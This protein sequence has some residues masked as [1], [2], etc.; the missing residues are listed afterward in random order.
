MSAAPW[1]AVS[2]LGSTGSIGTQALDV[3]ARSEP[4]SFTVT[5]LAATGGRAELLAE[6]AL[7]HHVATVAVT[8]PAQER[9]VRDALGATDVELL[10]GPGAAAALAERS[11]DLVVN[12][13]AGA[14]GL[15]STLAAVRAGNRVGLANKESLIIGGPVVLAALAESAPG[16]PVLERLLP[17]DSEHSALWQCLAGARPGSVAT[18]VLTASGG[19][20]RG[21][22]AETL[23][24]VTP[25]QAL[26]HPTWSMGP[27]ITVNSATLVN[28]GHELIEAAI[29]FA[30]YLTGDPYDAIDVVVHPQ[31]LIHSMVTYVD[32]STLAQ[33]SPPDMRLPISLALGFPERIPGAAPT[34]DWS[35]GVTMTFEPLDRVAFPAVELARAAGRAG[36]TSTAVFTA[37]NEAA[38]AAFLAGHA[39]FPSIVTVVER[40]LAEH[41]VVA[42]P[43]LEDVLHADREARIRATELLRSVAA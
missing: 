3:I 23:H 19:P 22:A 30:D 7:A 11:A 28:K 26:H 39:S 2:I 15:E 35:V 33:V 38:V 6:Q 32:G 21:R 27:M 1:R 16:V 31:S 8:D 20:F 18:L 13:V 43:S 37:A 34:M 40:V 25:D 10:V 29:L 41:S 12:G 36:G 17:I 24:D 14:A 42:T 5:G 4:G 9:A